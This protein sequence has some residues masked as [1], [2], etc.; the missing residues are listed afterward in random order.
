MWSR[1]LGRRTLLALARAFVPG[2]QNSSVPL[3]V[4]GAWDAG[5][6][7]RLVLVE[8]TKNI[9]ADAAGLR[10][11]RLEEACTRICW[12]RTF[13]Y[14]FSYTNLAR[15]AGTWPRYRPSS[16]LLHGMAHTSAGCPCLRPSRRLAQHH[17]L[18]RMRSSEAPL[19]CPELLTAAALHAS[20]V[21]R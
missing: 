6:L 10:K 20:A 1:C 16:R 21:W 3:R 12:T 11:L 2:A 5:G 9:A 7:A 14:C 8:V 15:T 13:M 4:H 17:K 18:W 19:Y